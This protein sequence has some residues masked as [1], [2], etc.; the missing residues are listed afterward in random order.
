MRS[1]RFLED[2]AIADTAFEARGE[3]PE[4]LLLAAADALIATIADPT[5]IQ[6]NLER[7]IQLSASDFPELL[8]LWLSELVFLKD[9]EPMVFCDADVSVRKDTSWE[10]TGHVRGDSIQ[11]EHLL[12]SDVK[13]VTKHMYNVAHDGNE[14]VAQVVLDI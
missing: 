14:W 3:T 2:I 6:P 9:A 4:E 1:H 5:T 11:D 12:G 8:F 13:A 7:D 10:L